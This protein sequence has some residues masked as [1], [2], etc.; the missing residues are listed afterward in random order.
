MKEKY[1]LEELLEGEMILRGRK[2]EI[3]SELPQDSMGYNM[4]H[5]NVY[6]YNE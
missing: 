6:D 2:P 3:T 5:H 1:T 4:F